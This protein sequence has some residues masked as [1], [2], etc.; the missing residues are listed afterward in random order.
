M[1]L[2]ETDLT[3]LTRLAAKVE[4]ERVVAKEEAKVEAEAATASGSG[5]MEA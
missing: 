3:E 4:A 2:T 5:S 1:Y